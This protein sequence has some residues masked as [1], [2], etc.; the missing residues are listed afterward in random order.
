MRTLVL[1]LGLILLLAGCAAPGQEMAVGSEPPAVEVTA[2]EA[3]QAIE[4]TTTAEPATALPTPTDPPTATLAPTPTLPPQTPLVFIGWGGEVGNVIR[5]VDAAT[6]QDAP[7]RA[8][9]S[10]GGD[11]ESTYAIVTALSADGRY[12]VAFD[13]HGNTCYD[14]AGGSACGPRSETLFLVDTA[15]W[16]SRT[17]PLDDFGWVGYPVFDAGTGRLAF[18]L[19]TAGGQSLL[20]FNAATGALVAQTA[21]DFKPAALGFGPDG[22]ILVYGQP[23][24]E[25]P[26]VSRPGAPRVQLRDGGTLAVLWETE[27]PDVVSGHWCSEKCDAGHGQQMTEMWWPGVALS[28]DG[29]ALYIVHA[30]EDRLT[31]V[32]L[33][34]RTV[35][36]TAI[37]GPQTRLGRLLAWLLD[38]T[39]GVAHAKGPMNGM[40]RS[41]ALSADGAR[42][43]VIGYR[44]QTETDA[45]GNFTIEETLL[46]LQVIDTAS[47]AILARSEVT[48]HTLSLSA[49]DE[50]VIVREWPGRWPVNHVLDAR[51]LAAVAEIEGPTLEFVTDTQGQPRLVGHQYINGGDVLSLYDAQTWQPVA[52]WPAEGQAMWP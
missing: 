45:S 46:P 38:A 7:G 6:G 25:Q 15:T 18:T 35:A 8:P 19:Q 13:S 32:N 16:Q 51:T 40:T 27:L 12:L 52:E 37:G 24:G 39:A 26:G 1:L 14:Y 41:V 29:G 5:A 3:I 23:E 44:L 20:I 48:G 11:R 43:Y 36:T 30:D 22:S 50:H 17:I 9:I 21:L 34:A 31:T 49:G 42:L 47:G 4:P 10:V 28:A 2:T 33:A